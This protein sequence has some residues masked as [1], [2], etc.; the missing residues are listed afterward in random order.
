MPVDLVDTVRLEIHARVEASAVVVDYRLTHQGEGEL[1][2]F[3]RLSSTAADG[4]SHLL[5][6]TVYVDP[7]GHVLH[8]KKLVLPKPEGL[9]MAAQIV[10]GIVIL[11]QGETL[12]EQIRVPVP[13]P[14]NNPNRLAMLVNEAGGA[15]FHASQ[16]AEATA[17]R[18]SLGIFRHEGSEKLIELSPAFPGVY[19]IW[20]PGPS[21]ARQV[22]VSADAPLA[23]PVT[24][25]DYAPAG[26]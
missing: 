25:L 4:A 16:P 15:T 6:E 22:V 18:L 2:V 5:P 3:D 8:L 11:R 26:R 10:P 19:R 21:V 17:V 7:E 13:V 12:A 23:P 1:G 20:P 14:A 24:M 9:Q